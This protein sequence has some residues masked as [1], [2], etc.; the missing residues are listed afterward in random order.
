[1]PPAHEGSLM[2]LAD[3]AN[4]STHRPHPHAASRPITRR[5][6]QQTLKC[7]IWSVIHEEMHYSPKEL[8]EFPNLCRQRSEG[9]WG[10]ILRVWDSN[11]KTIKLEQAKLTDMEP[12]R[13]S[14][15]F[16]ITA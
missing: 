6:L 14:S 16:T 13:T 9:A 1:M 10:W 7:E 5:K 15:G 11:G 3:T 12:L 4:F 8:H 2:C